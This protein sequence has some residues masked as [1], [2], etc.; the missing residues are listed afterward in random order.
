[1]KALQLHIIGLT[2]TFNS[3]SKGKYLQYFIPGIIVAFIFWHVFVVLG[4]AESSVSFLNDIPLL[5]PIL[6]W[7]L[8]GAFGIIKFILNQFFIFFVLTL[9]SPFNTLL[10][11]KVAF[12]LTGIKNKLD[13]ERL[14][15]D[16]VRMIIIVTIAIAMQLFFF[17]IY[18]IISS[19]LGLGIFD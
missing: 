14:F 11:E 19:I 16:I 15:S 6:G 10:S 17:F 12:D 8:G 5:G 2:K 1:M 9:L 13:F 4:T 18:F 3:L 7:I